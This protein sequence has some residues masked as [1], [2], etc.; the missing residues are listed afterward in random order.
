[1]WRLKNECMGSPDI[2]KIKAAIDQTMGEGTSELVFKTLKLVYHIE[3]D[4]IISNPEL[5]REKI[6]KLFGYPIAEM[7]LKAIS[8]NE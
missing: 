2:E 5:F 8:D 4:T 3:E 6:K 7:I 1:M